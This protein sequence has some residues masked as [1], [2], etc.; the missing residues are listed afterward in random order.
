MVPKFLKYGTKCHFLKGS[1]ITDSIAQ[2]YLWPSLSLSD[3]FSVPAGPLTFTFFEVNYL[4]RI[5][6]TAHALKR[7]VPS[8]ELSRALSLGNGILRPT[9]SSK[10]S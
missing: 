2:V 3:D 10:V 8:P 4:D 5:R 1:N 6:Q 7:F 9:M